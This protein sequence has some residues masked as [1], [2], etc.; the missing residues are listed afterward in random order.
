MSFS[1]TDLP[2]PLAPS[3]IVMLPLGTLK[4]TSL[5]HDVIVEGERDVL[6]RD[7]WRLRAHLPRL[8]TT[9]LPP[10]MTTFAFSQFQ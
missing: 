6:D 3:S 9:T 8:S 2:A 10:L 1:R 7:R 4:L 5:Q